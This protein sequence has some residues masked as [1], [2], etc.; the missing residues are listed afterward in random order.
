MDKCNTCGAQIIVNKLNH[1]PMIDGINI[2]VLDPNSGDVIT[3]A[4]FLNTKSRKFIKFIKKIKDGNVVIA[5][6]QLLCNHNNTKNIRTQKAVLYAFQLLG[7]R[8]QN[9]INPVI[10]RSGVYIYCKKN[11][12]KNVLFTMKLPFTSFM[13]VDEDPVI[14]SFT[15]NLKSGK[16]WRGNF[17]IFV[18][19]GE[20]LYYIGM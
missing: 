1:S 19:V 10:F 15:I 18:W 13:R 11:C 17:Y 5:T 7:A 6:S 9:N 3:T 16:Y 2:A 4:S 20:T 8:R 12:S 14:V